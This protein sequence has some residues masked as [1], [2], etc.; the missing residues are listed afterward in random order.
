MF[1]YQTV[2]GRVVSQILVLIAIALLTAPLVMI[3]LI[4]LQ[5]EGAANYEI[6]IAT[7]PFLRFFFNSL[8]VS[9]TTVL[10]VL[11]CSIASAY[12]IAT[13]RPRGSR[14]AMIL[15]LAGMGWREGVSSEWMIT[16]APWREAG[17]I[18]RALCGALMLGASLCWLIQF[19]KS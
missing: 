13:L 3:A 17:L 16:H 7:T 19:K 9:V 12:A 14:V 15:I 5:G 8:V 4:S 18:A 1:Q 11:C 2:A 6:V 10:L